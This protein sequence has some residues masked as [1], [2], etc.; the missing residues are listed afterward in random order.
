MSARCS[1]VL[2]ST[3]LPVSPT[4]IVGQSS[5]VS[6]YTPDDELVFCL[7][8]LEMVEILLTGL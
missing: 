8:L 7:L 2:V 6:F 3:F 1:L 5:Q 4:Y